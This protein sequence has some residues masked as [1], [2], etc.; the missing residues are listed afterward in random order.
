MRIN[1]LFPGKVGLI[2]GNMNVD[3]RNKVLNLFVNKK[4][5]ILVST[6]IIEVGINFPDANIIII[7]DAN[8][9]G[10][11][12]LHQLRGRVGRG[13]SFLIVF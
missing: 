2:H 12:Q 10:L 9:F 8:K 3:E 13:S 11:S 7:E 5:K 4:I 6:T 1:K